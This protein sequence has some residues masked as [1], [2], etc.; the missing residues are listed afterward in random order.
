MKRKSL[1]L[2]LLLMLSWGS[3][4][5]AADFNY[6]GSGM[7]NM[8]GTMWDFMEWFLGRREAL[9]RYSTLPR[10]FNS[11]MLSWYDNSFMRSAGTP[12]R[13]HQYWNESVSPWMDMQSLDGVW[14]AQS[15]EYWYVRKNRFVLVKRDDSRYSGEFVLEGNFILVRLPWGEIEFEYRQMDDALLLR[16]VQGRLML[17]RRVEEGGWRW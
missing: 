11:P 2:L 4:L 3:A 9:S 14:L 5:P 10:R 12:Y 15:G 1:T 8:M 13:Q 6:R 7:L 17:L 16:D